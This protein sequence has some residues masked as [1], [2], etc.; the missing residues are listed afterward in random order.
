[1]R[2]R[3]RI[4]VLASGAGTNFQS[5]IDGVESG[6]VNAEIAALIT[7]NSSATAIER[8]KK[9]NVP[10]FVFDLKSYSIREDFDRALRAKLDELK[11]D[12]VVLAGYMK[13]IKDVKFLHDYARKIINIH[14]SLLPAFG[15][16]THAQTNAFEYGVKI[17]G[18]TIHFVDESTDGGP[19]IHQEAVDISKCKTAE[20]VRVKILEMEHLGLPMII[21]SFSKGQWVVEGRKTRFVKY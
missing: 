5:I 17:S 3:M 8:A 14:P 9:H 15:A 6:K 13:L 4:A 7:D 11:V 2:G 20:E 10:F 12:L 1:M 16:T 19:I 21:D 18:Y